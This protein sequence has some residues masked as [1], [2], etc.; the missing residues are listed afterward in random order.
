MFRYPLPNTYYIPRISLLLGT[1]PT[2]KANWEKEQMKSRANYYV[3]TAPRLRLVFAI[4]LTC[5][6]P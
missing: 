1:L 2:M 5:P 3:R 6:P 4:G